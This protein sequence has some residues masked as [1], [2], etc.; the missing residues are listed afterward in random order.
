MKLFSLLR[1]I[2]NLNST[3][4]ELSETLLAQAIL[5]HPELRGLSLESHYS[6]KKIRSPLLRYVYDLRSER[7]RELTYSEV[8][9]DSIENSKRQE[10]KRRQEEEIKWGILAT[11]DW[12]N[13]I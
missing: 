5:S 8:V 4:K 7:G 9:V 3:L 2:V 11:P 13:R 1:T 10:E 6:R 12:R